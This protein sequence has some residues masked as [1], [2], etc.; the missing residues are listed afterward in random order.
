MIDRL[1]RPPSA[2]LLLLLGLALLILSRPRLAAEDDK[3][4]SVAR[5]FEQRIVTAAA[6]ATPT[7]VSIRRPVR[8]S[9]RGLPSRAG[10][11]GV[12]IRPQF[13]LTN[14]H[15]VQ[16]E[17]FEVILADGRAVPGVVWARDPVGDLALLKVATRG[18]KPAIMGDSE[19]VQL[20]DPVIAVGNALG[21]AMENGEPAV[22]FGIISA[23]ERYQGGTRTYGDALQFDAAVNP[24]NS[25][26]GL[27]D[28]EGR[29]LGITGR[30]SVRGRRSRSVGVGFAVPAHQ[31]ALVLD[32]LLEGQDI[33][34]GFLGVRFDRD[35][36]GPGVRVIHVLPGSPADSGDLR[37]GDLLLEVD[38]RRV[39]HPM[40][41]QNALSI[42]P[43]GTTV[44]FRLKRGLE[45]IE[46]KAVL[47]P[48]R[49]RS[50]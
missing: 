13:V 11:S 29:L 32:R 18:L 27:F 22:S 44:T 48:Q 1:R 19:A 28:L 9:K 16:G 23:T 50:R 5:A 2:V 26:G 42:L 41:L 21:L 12:L 4:R 38:G 43:A 15:V 45:T 47:A 3:P 10:G 37:P 40:R 31:I 20:G 36:P 39:D 25:G 24:G 8:P 35:A 17:R 14:D 49:R 7:V 33:V 34:R 6:I 46:R 30:I